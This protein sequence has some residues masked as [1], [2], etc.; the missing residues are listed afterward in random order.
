[1]CLL[2]AG[3][4]DSAPLLRKM[5]SQQKLDASHHGVRVENPPTAET[6]NRQIIHHTLL[7]D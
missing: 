3:E 7:G 2:G 1:M 5:S 4:R 6:V